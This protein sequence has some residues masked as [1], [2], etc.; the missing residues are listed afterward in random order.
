MFFKKARR[1]FTKKFPSPLTGLLPVKETF[2]S[3]L[4]GPDYLLLVNYKKRKLD[5]VHDDCMLLPSVDEEEEERVK[6]IFE[7]NLYKTKFTVELENFLNY[8]NIS[9]NP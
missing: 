4:F 5:H 7:E 6:D 1:Y 2:P 9:H 3:T 8:L